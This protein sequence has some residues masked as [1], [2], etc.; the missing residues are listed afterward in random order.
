M[1]Y[2]LFAILIIVT[3]ISCSDKYQCT[4]YIDGKAYN[5]YETDV[6][7]SNFEIGNSWTNY[8]TRKTICY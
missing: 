6:D 3:C 8:A 4:V 2:I 7:E 5:Q 1:K